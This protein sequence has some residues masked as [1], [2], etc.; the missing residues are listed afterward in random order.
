MLG[1]RARLVR[2]YRRARAVYWSVW[3]LVMGAVVAVAV[4]C[5]GRVAPLLDQSQTLRVAGG[6]V[7]CGALVATLLAIVWKVSSQRLLIAAE[8]RLGLRGRLSSAIALSDLQGPLR[9][10]MLGDAARVA[11]SV[12][13]REAVPV[14]VSRRALVL[15]PVLVL[16]FSALYFTDNP[17]L[18]VL[19]EKRA[20][21]SAQRE[22]AKAIRQTAKRLQAQASP[23]DPAAQQALKELDQLQKDLQQGKLSREAAAARASQAEAKIQEASSRGPALSRA[24]LQRAASALAAHPST[25]ALAKALRSGDRAAIE[26]QARQL[27]ESLRKLKPDERSRADQ[28]LRAA[29]AATGGLS[30]ELSAAL[31]SAAS[32]TV[33]SGQ[34]LADAL[35]QAAGQ[36]QT[37]DAIESALS[38]VQDSRE[39][40]ANAGT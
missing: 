15:L 11:R 28:A 13:W 29:A 7:V 12:S 1:A 22:Q 19:A 4:A 17:Q 14:A 34:K 3:G 5:A 25:E 8:L 24:A 39:Q 36:A 9:R 20:V 18:P 38:Q 10:E 32:G 40:V 33:D 31:D 30:P 6:A 37:A 2:R 16:A 21:A 35:Q 23:K 26:R 27:A